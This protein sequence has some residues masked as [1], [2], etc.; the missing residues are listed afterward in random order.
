MEPSASS[1]I[2]VVFDDKFEV[3]G[4]IA[5]GGMGVVYRGTDKS[6]GRSVA[7]KVLQQQF[8]SDAESVARFRREARAMAALDHP[9]IVPVFAIG[10]QFGGVR[11]FHSGVL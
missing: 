2:N 7:I 4:E 8:N 6:L 1:L 9:N 3:L 5:R 10:H 11:D